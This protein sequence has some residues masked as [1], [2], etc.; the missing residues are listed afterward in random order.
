M[1]GDKVCVLLTFHRLIPE[2]LG[3]RS[4]VNA[5]L[6]WGQELQPRGPLCQ[7]LL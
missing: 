6:S 3:F 4:H 7:R 1:T 5:E 2:D